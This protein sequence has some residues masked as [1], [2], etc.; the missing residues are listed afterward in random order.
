MQ[1]S[2]VCNNDNTDMQFVYVINDEYRYMRILTIHG[3]G[4]V[5]FCCA[6]FVAGNNAIDA[7]VAEFAFLDNQPRY[8]IKA[9]GDVIVLSATATDHFVIFEPFN[10]GTWIAKVNRA[11]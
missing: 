3:D 8:T 4:A 6:K 9:T 1:S 7:G 5:A 2:P 10:G 11:F